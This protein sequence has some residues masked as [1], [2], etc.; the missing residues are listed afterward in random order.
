V[1]HARACGIGDS[2][3]L[4]RR[5][6]L[7]DLVDSTRVQKYEQTGRRAV[8]SKIAV[9]ANAVLRIGIAYFLAE[10]L[11][12]PNDPRFAGK[13]IPIRNLLIVGGLS[14]LF[15]LVHARSTRWPRY[16]WWVDNLHLSIFFLDMAG[17]SFNLYDRYSHFDLIPHFHGTGAFTV[18]LR[19]GF[20]ASASSAAVIATALH[21]LLEVQEMLTDVLFGTHN[22]RGVSDTVGD[23]A[24]GMLGTA[25]YNIVYSGYYG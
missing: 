6:R 9:A 12:K 25:T 2:T 11:L 16:P 19:A 20:G 22:V 23:L 18:V 3:G 17:N 5:C 1:A 13:A 8:T 15:P 10:V 24:A 7:A 4:A 21:T 14:L